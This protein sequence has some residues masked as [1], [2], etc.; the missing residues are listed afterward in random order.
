MSSSIDFVD[1]NAANILNTILTTL[2]N[3]CG[4]PLF[5]GDERRIFGE[6][7]LAPLFVT[8]FNAVNDGCRQRLLR[9]ARG[10]VLDA[11]GE[12]NHCERIAAAKAETTLRFS[13]ASVLGYNIF[14]PAGLRVTG[15]G[16]YF[17]SAEAT[18]IQ[19][20]DTYAD[21]TGIAVSGGSEYN[22]IDPGGINEIVDLS[23]APQLSNVTNTTE[24]A[25]GTD[26]ESDNA[27]RNRIR[28]SSNAI[29]TAGPEA[30]YRFY[31]ISADP[32][33]I[34]DAIVETDTQTVTKTLA[35]K[36]DPLALL[37]DPSY[38]CYLG[39]DYYDVD[40][41]VVYES[42][43]STPAILETDYSVDYTDGLLTIAELPA[44]SIENK[45]IDISISKLGAG[46]VRITPVRYDGTLP[47]Q[48]LLDKVLAA[49]TDPQTKP[50]TDQVVVQAPTT[51]SF[52]IELTYYTTAADE[53]VCIT[54]VEG[55]GGA[56]DQ[57]IEWQQGGLNR[58]IN[59]DMLSKLILAP[60]GDGAVG[61]TR[62]VITKPVYTDLDPTVLAQFSGSKV[63]S[64]VVKEGVN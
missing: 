2:E 43:S 34:A 62:V 48:T 4:E 12:N 46:T 7:A 54:T 11:L 10:E 25:G 28:L 26:A 42:G 17:E 32:E 20:G 44:G 50:L 63:V 55:T 1:V 5:P 59:P 37:G 18:V 36:S 57:Y 38:F 29:S 52:D 31:A 21:V 51:Q 53:S 27:Y 24:T 64:H 23:L 61:A 41:L 56:I 35:P 33:N 49:C 47:D 40:S 14:I 13:I 8:L 58:D 60:K 30:A 22:G 15:E 45:S 19:A 6:S 16:L 39:G 3:G 9:Y